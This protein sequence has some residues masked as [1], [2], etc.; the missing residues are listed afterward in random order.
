MQSLIEFLSDLSQ[1]SFVRMLKLTE[2][3]FDSGQEFLGVHVFGG[4]E[5]RGLLKKSFFQLRLFALDFLWIKSIF[6]VG[7]GRI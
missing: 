3:S 2:D 5:E 4:L 6:G 1:M 7:H